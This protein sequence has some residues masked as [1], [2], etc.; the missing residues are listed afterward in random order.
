MKGIK[1]FKGSEN[2]VEHQQQALLEGHQVKVFS[3]CSTKASSKQ[4]MKLKSKVDMPPK[5]HATQTC[6]LISVCVSHLGGSA[7]S[8][9]LALPELAWL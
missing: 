1:K 5:K 9:A 2:T 3:E 4:L 7:S 8:S 6:V